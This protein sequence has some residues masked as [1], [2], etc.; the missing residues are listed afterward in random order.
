MTFSKAR[1][2]LRCVMDIVVTA[3]AVVTILQGFGLL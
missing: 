1:A 3:A 2:R